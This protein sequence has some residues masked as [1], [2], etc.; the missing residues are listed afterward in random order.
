[1]TK[2]RRMTQ[3]ETSIVEVTNAYKCSIEKPKRRRPLGRPMSRW[4]SIN[5]KIDL[6]K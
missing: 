1:M 3:G 6:K 4:K 5:I 2:S